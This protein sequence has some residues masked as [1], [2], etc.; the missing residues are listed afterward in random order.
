MA[1]THSTIAKKN[2]KDSHD[3]VHYS[4]NMRQI[5]FHP[6]ARPPELLYRVFIFNL[7]TILNLGTNMLE[8]ANC[9]MYLASHTWRNTSTMTLPATCAHES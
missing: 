2:I 9:Y 4:K 5:Y 3:T 8:T 1:M 6:F 7:G